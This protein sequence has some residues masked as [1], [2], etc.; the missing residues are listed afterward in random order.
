MRAP[1]VNLSHIMHRMYTEGRK[2]AQAAARDIKPSDTPAHTPTA[3]RDDDCGPETKIDMCDTDLS[4]AS[5]VF[6]SP[7]DSALLQLSNADKSKNSANAVFILPVDATLSPST[8]TQH[9]LGC[10]HAHALMTHVRVHC[11]CSRI[12]AEIPTHRSAVATQ[13]LAP[14]VISFKSI[15]Q[16]VLTPPP[17]FNG[18]ML[19]CDVVW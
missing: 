1:P 14:E 19:V 9:T 8:Q 4:S 16:P 17:R 6:I 11:V 2:G 10:A 13:P 3:L 18:T 7:T 5:A 15:P 12:Q